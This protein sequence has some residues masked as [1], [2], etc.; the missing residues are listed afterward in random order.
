MKKRYLTVMLKLAA[1]IL[2]LM[3]SASTSH[4]C[5]CAMPPTVEKEVERSDAVFSGEAVSV[6]EQ[7]DW[8]GY[9][10]KEVLF[11]VKSTWKGTSKSQAII[12]T[13]TGGGD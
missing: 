12:T 4:A 8:N 6:K 3:V 11:D 10:R 1:I 13:G 9:V 7:K 2:S 5:S